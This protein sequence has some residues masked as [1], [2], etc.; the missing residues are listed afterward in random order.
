MKLG[1]KAECTLVALK[2]FKY[3]IYPENPSLAI[4]FTDGT[5]QLMK[6]DQDDSP[7]LINTQ[8]KPVDC[9]WNHDGTLLA[10]AGR[11]SDSNPGPNQNSIN[12]YTP[13]GKLIRTMKLPGNQIAGLS[14]EGHS[15]RL[16]F[17]IDSFI[18]LAQVKHDYMWTCF[19]NTL[20]YHFHRRN[21]PESYVM[22]WDTKNN[23]VN[24][25]LSTIFIF[26]LFIHVAFMFMLF[27]V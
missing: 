25:N 15:L 12:F 18:Y 14:W 8:L 27:L 1:L 3:S 23:E 26:R 24:L 6:S 10:I 19:S 13:L 21:K 17:A 22:F 5:L 11:S 9:Q 2:W 16:A 7:I 4:L 20:V